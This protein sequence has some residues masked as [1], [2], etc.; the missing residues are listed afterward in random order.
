M[1]KYAV[2]VISLVIGVV[3]IFLI[4][5]FFKRAFMPSL[6]LQ[7]TATSGEAGKQLYLRFTNIG[8]SDITLDTDSMRLSLLSL[9]NKPNVYMIYANS[10]SGGGRGGASGRGVTLAPQQSFVLPNF[11]AAIVNA[12]SERNSSQQP[13]VYASYES[14]QDDGGRYW[15][16]NV[17]SFPMTLDLTDG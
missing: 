10:D 1:N 5:T 4:H 15:H 16:G 6:Y 8:S 14:L 11:R 12:F 7:L 2:P 13:L 17:K 3:S 9:P